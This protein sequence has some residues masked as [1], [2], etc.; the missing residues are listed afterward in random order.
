[1]WCPVAIKRLR[2]VNDSEK[3]RIPRIYLPDGY[4]QPRH[5]NQATG[6]IVLTMIIAQPKA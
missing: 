1:M 6:M 4:H 3:A 5:L 2:A